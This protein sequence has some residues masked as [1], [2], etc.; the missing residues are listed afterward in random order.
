METHLDRV[1]E[2]AKPD[3]VLYLAGVDVVDGD[4]FG[5]LKL[6][7]DGLARRDHVVLQSAKQRGISMTLVLAGGYAKTAER[8]AYLH[9]AVHREARKTHR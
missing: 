5:R 9:A 3:L 1:Y 2:V 4:R 7:G 8:T 6:T